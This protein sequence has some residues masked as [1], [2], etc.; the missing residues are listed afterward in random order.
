[1]HFL[2]EKRPIL[3]TLQSDNEPNG[4]DSSAVSVRILRAEFSVRGRLAVRM[5]PHLGLLESTAGKSGSEAGS[6]GGPV[7]LAPYETPGTHALAK[8]VLSYVKGHT[9]ILLVNHRIVCW[10]AQ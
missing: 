10:A 9:T 7:A 1:M 4:L 5:P 8:T 3:V 6:F 2:K